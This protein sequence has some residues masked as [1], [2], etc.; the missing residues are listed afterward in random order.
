M[1]RFGYVIR[2]GGDPEIAGALAAAVSPKPMPAAPDAVRRVAMHQHTPEEWAQMTEDARAFYGRR[3][4]PTPRW[5]R[6]LLALYALA[7]YGVSLAYHRQDA[8]L[9]GGA[10]RVP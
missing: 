1:K 5:A 9:G 6:A 2:T 10:R 3:S 8:L 7:C 4:W